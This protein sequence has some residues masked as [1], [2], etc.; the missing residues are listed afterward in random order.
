MNSSMWSS[1][2]RS[3]A[4]SSISSSSTTTSSDDASGGVQGVRP[5]P[6]HVASGSADAVPARG[7]RGG[8]GASS[9]SSSSS[10][11][12]ATELCD[13]GVEKNPSPSEV[14]RLSRYRPP[15]TATPAMR[16]PTTGLSSTDTPTYR[17]AAASTATTMYTL[18]VLLNVSYLRRMQPRP[19]T[20]ASDRHS[21]VE[22]YPS[23][24]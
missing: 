13:S 9:R 17:P 3:L 6:S 4:S 1:S 16:R 12:T 15:M 19:R 14:S 2:A 21:S 20:R 7:R 8:S 11:S 18:T 23:I 24:G 10:S 5:S 22:P